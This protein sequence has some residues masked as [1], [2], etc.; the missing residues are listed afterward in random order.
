MPQLIFGAVIVDGDAD[1]V[2]L[3]EFFETRKGF[4]CG[5]ARDD[6]VDASTLRVFE[7]GAHVGVVV[8]GEGNGAGGVKG[9]AGGS[10]VGEGGLFGLRI[11]G[12]MIF[13][14]LNIERED[15]ELFHEGDELGAIEIAEGVA[16]DA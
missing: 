4:G 10:V 1:V 2:L 3:H 9:D 11:G 12:E 14:V 13:Y 16:G 7:F 15:V 6:D 8:F 5:I